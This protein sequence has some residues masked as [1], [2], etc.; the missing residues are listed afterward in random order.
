M[1]ASRFNV[2]L[3]AVNKIHDFIHYAISFTRC[4]CDWM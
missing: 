4:N 2:S 1:G 3:L